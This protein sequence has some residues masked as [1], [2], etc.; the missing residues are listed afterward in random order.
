MLH[1]TA[2]EPTTSVPAAAAASVPLAAKGATPPT[3]SA[4]N[5]KRDLESRLRQRVRLLALPDLP[6]FRQ[7][8]T[9]R[10]LPCRRVRRKIGSIGVTKQGVSKSRISDGQKDPISSK[11]EQL[12]ATSKFAKE[13][14]NEKTAANGLKDTE[15]LCSQIS[16]DNPVQQS[17]IVTNLIEKASSVSP[18]A[19][20]LSVVSEVTVID[21]SS[22][23]QNFPAN[24]V[25]TS[26]GMENN[27]NG[28]VV[29][30]PNSSIPKPTLAVKGQTKVTKDEKRS[31][32]SGS[33]NN[34][35]SS[36]PPKP[37]Q[38]SPSRHQ[39]VQRRYICSCP[40]SGA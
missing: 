19:S 23:N 14:K 3:A 7:T 21:A 20:S 5:P 2:V 1:K 4:A 36:S 13:K 38:R 15:V 17:K 9:D 27:C 34:L 18:T 28:Q 10:K 26:T 32:N 33:E 30:S 25:P 40:H 24:S 22:I 8:P 35:S 29:S 31:Q 37:Y 12:K 39:T 11:L 6:V 16:P